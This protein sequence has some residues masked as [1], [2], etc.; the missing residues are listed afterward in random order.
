MRNQCHRPQLNVLA[1]NIQGGTFSLQRDI[2]FL[3]RPCF[4]GMLVVITL[5]GTLASRQCREAGGLITI[6]TGHILQQLRNPFFIWRAYFS[7]L[8]AIWKFNGSISIT[9]LQGNFVHVQV[10][11]TQP[12]SFFSGQHWKTGCGCGCGGCAKCT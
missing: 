8:T 11:D 9:R 4:N 5:L 7:L 1:K 12:L 3:T 10:I 2:A 6:T